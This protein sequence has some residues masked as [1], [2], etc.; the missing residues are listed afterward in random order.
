MKKR[1]DEIR[2]LQKLAGLVAEA[3]LSRSVKGLGASDAVPQEGIPI[4]I[5]S[6]ED[7][8]MDWDAPGPGYVL[9]HKKTAT[10]NTKTYAEYYPQETNRDFLISQFNDFVD[11]TENL[12]VI[13]HNAQDSFSS[14]DPE[15]AYLFY[16]NSGFEEPMVGGKWEDAL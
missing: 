13:L 11:P 10:R 14:R 2:K 8:N 6:D 3:P 12:V 7:G 16:D 15:E 1:L 9:I 4:K 5:V